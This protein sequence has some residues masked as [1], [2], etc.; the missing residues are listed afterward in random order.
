MEN[1]EQLIE[2]T[3]HVKAKL[4]FYIHL[5]VY[6]IVNAMLV[7]INLSTSTEHLWFKWPL[8]GWGIGIFVHA[9]VVFCLSRGRRIRQCMI[10]REMNKMASKT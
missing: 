8:A 1:Q 4:G 9:L 7:A 10:D 3:K 5:A 2:A 6:V